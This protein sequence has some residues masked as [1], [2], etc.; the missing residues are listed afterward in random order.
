MSAR[1]DFWQLLRAS[2]AGLEATITGTSM[3][4][5]LP[6]GAR[7]RIRP[8]ADE[9]YAVGDVVV[10][11]LKDALYAHRVVRR[12]RA[13]GATVLVTLGD[14]RALCDPPVRAADALGRIEACWRDEDWH[15]LAPAPPRTPIAQRLIAANAWLLA[16]CARLHYGMAR[17][18]Q[19]TLL[20]AVHLP[21]SLRAR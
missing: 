11:V 6:D 14:H 17:R 20:Q 12:G 21:L 10:C 7:V 3:L 1:P 15:G 5:T 9:D 19:G 8:S 18:V 13:G 16:A 2:G 4:P